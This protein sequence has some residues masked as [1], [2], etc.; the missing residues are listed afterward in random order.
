MKPSLQTSE[1]QSNQIIEDKSSM[2]ERKNRSGRSSRRRKA[3]VRAIQEAEEM[4][5]KQIGNGMGNESLQG[6]DVKKSQPDHGHLSVIEH[7]REKDIHQLDEIALIGQLGYFPENAIAIVARTSD[8]PLLQKY[9]FPDENHHDIPLVLQLYPIALRNCFSGGKSDGR[10]FKGRRRGPSSI[11]EEG[12]SKSNQSHVIMEPFPT[13]Y[14]L[15]HPLLR[16]LISKLEIGEECNVKVLEARLASD[17]DA[18]QSMKLAHNAYGLA[19]WE[20]LTETDKLEMECR[21]WKTSLDATC[22]IA[23]IRKSHAIKCLH[24]HVAHYL[25]RGP[26]SDENIVGKWVMEEVY[27]FLA[28][29]CETDLAIESKGIFE[30]AP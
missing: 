8:V 5:W 26:G 30:T 29:R 19:R 20:M 17:D 28:S 2:G 16:I 13:I 22:G 14:W 7:G 12:I 4:Y 1:L 11:P 27:K 6:D 15:T 9:T 10:K 23:G 25:S 18:M 21:G 3:K 24:T